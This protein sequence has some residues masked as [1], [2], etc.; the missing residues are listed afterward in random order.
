MQDASQHMTAEAYAALLENHQPMLL[1][2]GELVM[3][4]SPLPQHQRI[5]QELARRLRTFP[6][7]L[8]PIFA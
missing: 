5:V 8:K 7:H 3:S 1:I 6:I 2:H 4:L